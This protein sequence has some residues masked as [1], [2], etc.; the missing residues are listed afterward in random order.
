MKRFSVSL[1]LWLFV[2]FFFCFVFRLKGLRD[3]EWWQVGN[4]LEELRGSCAQASSWIES[5]NV[6]GRTPP[7]IFL[8]CR[9]SPTWHLVEFLRDPPKNLNPF[10][11]NEYFSLFLFS[12]LKLAPFFVAQMY[13]V[14]VVCD[15]RWFCTTHFPSVTQRR[16]RQDLNFHSSSYS[17]LC[18]CSDDLIR[19]CG[20]QRFSPREWCRRGFF[21]VQRRNAF[22]F[23]FF[24]ISD[25]G[26]WS[27]GYFKLG[28]F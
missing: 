4:W 12:G 20:T 5:G 15:F 9:S 7:S 25:S 19:I 27:R 3:F 14:A 1:F 10:F 2:F 23:L 28:A 24:F 21:G 22:Y 13:R 17:V 8:S 18:H 11:F 16:R 26:G 6:V